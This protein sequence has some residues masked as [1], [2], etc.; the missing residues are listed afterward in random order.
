M[1]S[2]RIFER[3]NE[4]GYFTENQIQWL[5]KVFQCLNFFEL[6]KYIT[7]MQK[8]KECIILYLYS[9]VV[10]LSKKPIYLIIL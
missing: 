10:V 8:E 6:L 5:N 7:A 9:Q 3:Y 1:K 4:F 2:R